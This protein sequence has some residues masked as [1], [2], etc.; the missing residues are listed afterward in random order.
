MR[1]GNVADED[2]PVVDEEASL[3]RP[4]SLAVVDAK[5]AKSPMMPRTSQGKYHVVK[6][7]K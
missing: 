7:E 2:P 3:V 1:L 6:A 5:V 4:S